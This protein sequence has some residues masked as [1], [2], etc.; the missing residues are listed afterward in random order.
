LGFMDRVNMSVVVPVWIVKY[1]LNPAVAGFVLSIFS[2]A[3]AVGLFFAGPVATRWHQ[4]RVLPLGM[5]LWTGATWI[6]A[7]MFSV[8][9]FTFVR[10]LLG[11]GESVLI[12]SN[13]RIASEIFEKDNLAKAVG[14]FYA[15][16][17]VGLAIGAPIA[18]FILARMGWQAVFLVT[19]AFS[20]IWLILW[21]PIY[22]PDKGVIS[23]GERVAAETEQFKGSRWTSLLLN[24]QTWGIMIG[25]FGAL[26]MLYVYITWL[27]GILALQHH[28]SI[29][30]AGWFTSLIF[31]VNVVMIIICGWISDVW[32]RHGG[33][34]TVVRKTF[35]CGGMFLA[36]VCIVIAAYVQDPTIIII[37][38]ILAI[39]GFAMF[40]P[41]AGV[42][43]IDLAPRHTIPSLSGLQTFFGNIG[44]ALAP[45]LTGFLYAQTGSFQVA[46]LTTAA[47]TLIFGVGGF[48]LLLGKVEKSVS[49]APAVAEGE[50]LPAK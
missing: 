4:K 35:C 15:G 42:L 16:S 45:L 28:F 1:H 49:L 18:A 17:Q 20:I 24:R 48:G 39:S 12:P 13:T 22:R 29:L 36:T 11:L 46:L 25:Q 21:L 8:P 43:P 26:Y 41:A 44:S 14:T 47:I 9:L 33:D 5:V 38:L 10:I 30:S 34:L 23:E 31:L 27:P 19:G 7:L 6:T 40:V 3:Y 32:L 37:M 50:I 2:W